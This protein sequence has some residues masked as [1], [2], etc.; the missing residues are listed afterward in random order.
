MSYILYLFILIPIS[1]TVSL[2]C[3]F[4]KLLLLTKQEYCNPSP[5]HG[6]NDMRFSKAK[7]FKTH[8]FII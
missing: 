4:I 7:K 3:L 1:L 8:S 6:N 2:I 5:K